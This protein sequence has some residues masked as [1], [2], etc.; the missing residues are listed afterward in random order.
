MSFEYVES[1]VPFNNITKLG[2]M[3]TTLPPRQCDSAM[4]NAQPLPLF[5]ATRLKSNARLQGHRYKITLQ[6]GSEMQLADSLTFLELL[7]ANGA[8]VKNLIGFQTSRRDITAE[9]VCSALESEK[10][11][12]NAMVLYLDIQGFGMCSMP[13]NVK[14]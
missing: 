6:I 5:T 8:A 2:G 7:N 11:G 10:G 12:R 3:H 9:W 4:P 1:R 14:V 13:L